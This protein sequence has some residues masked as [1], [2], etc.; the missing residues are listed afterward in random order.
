M[1]HFVLSKHLGSGTTRGYN[2]YPWDVFPEERHGGIDCRLMQL[3]PHVA[4]QSG[5]SL[6]TVPGIARQPELD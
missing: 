2:V 3:P 1:P 4:W 5:A 6:K